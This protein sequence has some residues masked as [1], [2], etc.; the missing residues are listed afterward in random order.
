MNAPTTKEPPTYDELLE[1]VQELRV[2]QRRLRARVEELAARIG[3]LEDRQEAD[4][5]ATDPEGRGVDP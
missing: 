5:R 2:S 1:G 3:R 4:D